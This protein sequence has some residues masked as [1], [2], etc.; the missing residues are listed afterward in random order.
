MIKVL[1]RQFNNFFS[2]SVYNEFIAY[3]NTVLPYPADFRVSE[4]PLFLSD[5]MYAELTHACSDIIEQ[6]RSPEFH[7]HCRNAVPS[8]FEVPKEDSHPLFLQIDFAIAQVEEGVLRPQL[9]EL[10]GFPSLYGFQY[11]LL[12]AI[13][14]YF[15]ITREFTSFF[16]GFSFSSYA[17]ELKK[18]I[19]GNYSA[20][21]T[22]LM[23][24]TPTLQKTRIDFAATERLTGIKTVDITHIYKDGKKLFYKDDSG[25]KVWIERIYNRTIIDELVRKNITLNFDYRD[26]LDVSW[27]GHPNWFYKISKHTLPYLKGKYVPD[28]FSLA[29]CTEYPDD[30]S[31][32][33]LKPLFSFAGLGVDVEPTREKLDVISDKE[34]YI[35]QKKVEYAPLIQTPDDYSRVEIR[36]MF[37]WNDEPLLVNNLI[38][39]SKGKMMGVDFN[40][41]KTWVGSSLAFH[42]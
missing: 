22:I 8:Q 21:D 3:L 41:N 27:A 40:K 2:E 35:L 1:R 12:E 31:N 10:Q 5:E 36:M 4:T 11:Y 34:N 38:R 37:L 17:E 7:V 25:K 20:D 29:S 26:E 32:Y 15:P 33:V 24:I 19:L 42:G 30:L 18:S 6:L 28:C 9:I 13:Q 16:S 23:E 39:M 14:K